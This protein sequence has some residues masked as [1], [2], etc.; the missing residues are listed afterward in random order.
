VGLLC[1]L[2]KHTQLATSL[3]QIENEFYSTIRPKRV[4]RPGERA[5]HALRDRGVE[6]I[7]VRAM[8]L[9]PFSAIGITAQTMRFLDIFLLH[10]LLNDSPP[11]TPQEIAAT[12]IRVPGYVR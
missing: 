12:V 2:F 5:L 1:R 10:C 9:D 3:L 8:D 11:D 4:V 6:D 7:E